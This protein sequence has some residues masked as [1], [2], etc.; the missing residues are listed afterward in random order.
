[1]KLH[2]K[3]NFFTSKKTITLKM[4]FNIKNIIALTLIIFFGLNVQAQFRDVNKSNR[5][6]KLE[7]TFGASNGKFDWNRVYVGGQFGGG[8]ANSQLQGVISPEVG[9]YLTESLLVA[10]GPTYEFLRVRL[11]QANNDVFNARYLGGHL[12]ARYNVFK[13][14]FAHAEYEYVSY[15]ENGEKVID[16][17][18]L[19][20]I[21]G[22][23][24][25]F[26]GVGLQIGSFVSAM[27]LY[28]FLYDEDAP[29]QRYSNPLGLNFNNPVIRISFGG[30]IGNLF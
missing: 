20:T 9:Y 10:G 23:N 11:S 30:N 15:R 2:N 4:K 24:S 12:F 16:S 7:E 28:N 27:V 1:M 17:R 3:F 21:N 18:T 26:T 22:I 5:A 8:L 14:F 29:F 13:G 6:K 25:L 19:E